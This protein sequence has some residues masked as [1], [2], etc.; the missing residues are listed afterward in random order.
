MASTSLA[1][2]LTPLTVKVR[3]S[4]VLPPAIAGIVAPGNGETGVPLAAVALLVLRP[5]TVVGAPAGVATP[6]TEV[7][8]FASVTLSNVTVRGPALA[9]L[10]V[11]L[12]V[13][14]STNPSA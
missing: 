14:P 7:V 4:M 13:A 1:P 5:V 12:S 9:G 8:V 6:S 2:S 3:V 11:L 10:A